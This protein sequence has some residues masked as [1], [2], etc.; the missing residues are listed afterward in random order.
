M[1]SAGGMLFLRAYH[2]FYL[3]ASSGFLEICLWNNQTLVEV[4]GVIGS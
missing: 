4:E 3:E 2:S 1:T